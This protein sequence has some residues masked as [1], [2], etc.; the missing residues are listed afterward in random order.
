[1][2]DLL[3]FDNEFGIRSVIADTYGN[4]NA[5]KTDDP[6]HD[7]EEEYDLPPAQY[8]ESVSETGGMFIQMGDMVELE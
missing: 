1:M 4:S 3:G 8:D 2:S 5:S 7:E 6:A